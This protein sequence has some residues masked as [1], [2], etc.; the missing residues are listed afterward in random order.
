MRKLLD[1]KNTTALHSLP[2]KGGNY[3]APLLDLQSV[4]EYSAQMLPNDGPV[5]AFI[6]LNALHSLE[7]M[8]FDEAIKIGSKLFGCQ[9]YLSEDRYRAELAKRRIRFVDLQAVMEEDL[10]E[11]S[12]EPVAGLT[13]RLNLRVAMLR[14]SVFVVP[15]DELRWCMAEALAMTKFREETAANVRKDILADSLRWVVRDLINGPK[16]GSYVRPP[17]GDPRRKHILW[18]LLDRFGDKNID[19]WSD[20]TWEKF[21]VQALWTVC[22]HGVSSIHKTISH[23]ITGMRPRNLLMD[24]TEVDSD[25]L[26]NEILVRFCASYTD[27]GFANAPL[28]ARDK[29]FFKSFCKLYRQR[30]G[31][32]NRWLRGL[33]KELARLD[34][35][36][37]DPLESIHVS[38]RIL[39]IGADE[40]DEFFPATLLALRGWATIIR[41][42]EVRP[43]RVYVSAP[44]GTLTEFLAVRLI[45]E[46]Y[47]LAHVARDELDYH[48]SLH[49]LREAARSR[50]SKSKSPSVA[51]RT[52]LVFQ[53]AQLLGWTPSMLHGLAPA[54]WAHLIVEIEAFNSVERRRIFHAAFERRFRTRALDA[55]S[56]HTAKP[57]VKNPTPKFQAVFCIDTREL[58][59]RRH[60]EEVCPEVQTFGAPG[61]YGVAMYYRGVADAHYQALCP[62]VVRPQHWVTEEVV[63]SLEQTHR[64]RASAR[65]ALGTAQHQLHRGS[66]GTVAGAATAILGSLACIPLVARVLFPR[67]AAKLLK[68]AVT[69]MEPPPITR[70]VL[71]RIAATPGPEGDGIGFT[72]EEMANRGEKMLR[73]IG[74]TTIFSRLFFFFGHASQCLNNPHKSSYDCGACTGPGGPGARALAAMLNDARVREILADRGLTIPRDTIFIGGYHNTANDSFTFFDLDLLPKSHL[75]D[76]EEVKSILETTCERNAHERCRRFDSA[77]LNIPLAAAHR[78]VDRRAEDLAQ[79]R[80]EFGNATNA[81]CYVGRR[82]RIRG[83]YLD[84]RCFDHSYD[85]TEDD[86]NHSKLARILAPVVPVCQGINLTY[87]FSAI[88]NNTWGAGTKLPHNVA[89]LLGVMDGAASDLRQGLPWQSVEIHEPVRLLFVIEATPETMFKIMEDDKVVGRILKNGWSQLAILNPNS[90][91]LKLFQDGAFHIYQPENS[92]LPRAESSIDWYRGWRDHLEFAAISPG[93]VRDFVTAT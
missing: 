3:D 27:Q 42:M 68:Q 85:P 82:E 44:V 93:T 79:V 2:L 28:P 56:I 73:D 89:S 90:N 47:A 11:C 81:M 84:R 30:F 7:H 59:F 38:L 34:D 6:F 20:E 12:W 64:R 70:L 8:P 49:D 62:I 71:E 48:G 60:L 40:W 24:A 63:Y 25:V 35:E 77:P 91:E 31:P 58:G 14:H 41:Q 45:L 54:Q 29:G 83:L 92:V 53:L 21:S 86:A 75:K 26:V 69:F 80:P 19:N 15:D 18:N 50:I 57:V 9:P 55:I 74:A 67:A 87:F 10:K 16:D 51:Q 36:N 33:D 88:D 39:G 72:V 78:H 1:L 5:S 13:A 43:D 66:M 37:I 4:I 32:P 76:F 23:D 46:R 65:K 61:F 52:Y 22:R 17:E